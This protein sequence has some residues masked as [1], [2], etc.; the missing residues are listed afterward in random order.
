M[1]NLLV[2]LGGNSLFDIEV[3]D[4]S[5]PV[6]QH[7]AD[8][9]LRVHEELQDSRYFGPLAGGQRW[10]AEFQPPELT[11]S[12]NLQGVIA[13]RLQFFHESARFREFDR[14]HSALLAYTAPT[15][16]DSPGPLYSQSAEEPAT[17]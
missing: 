9:S 14:H 4:R 16:R 8:P 3:G 11:A 5:H 12:H 17:L 10:I 15:I 7:I 1:R 13:H 2:H 6:R